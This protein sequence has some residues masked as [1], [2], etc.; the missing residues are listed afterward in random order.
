MSKLIIKI[1]NLKLIKYIY[2]FKDKKMNIASRN[3][4]KLKGFIGVQIEFKNKKMK[5]IFQ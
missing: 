1:S 3:A 2:I 4:K 5:I